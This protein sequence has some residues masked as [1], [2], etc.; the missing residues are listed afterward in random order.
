MKQKYVESHRDTTETEQKMEMQQN[1]NGTEAEKKNNGLE[2]GSQAGNNLSWK[3]TKN[4]SKQRRPPSK[5][6]KR[7]Q[8]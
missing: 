8:P 7:K 5:Q 4:R 2:A 1:G 6:T 3:R